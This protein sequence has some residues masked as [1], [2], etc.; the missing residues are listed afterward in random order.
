MEHHPCHLSTTE[1]WCDWGVAA[2]VISWWRPGE[3]SATWR[4]PLKRAGRLFQPR[5]QP[6][7]AS[8][9]G[10]FQPDQPTKFIYWAAKR[11]ASQPSTPPGV[12]GWLEFDVPA[13]L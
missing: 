2:E 1:V 4:T 13:A 8:C 7:L 10:A 11:Y 5:Q 9:P 12:R 6:W 3:R